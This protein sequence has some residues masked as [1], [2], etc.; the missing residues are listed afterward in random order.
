MSKTVSISIT[1]RGT[2][3]KTSHDDV[4]KW[5]LFPR[6]YIFVVHTRTIY[7]TCVHTSHLFL[8]RIHT[9]CAYHGHTYTM[10][11]TFT[12]KSYIFTK[13]TYYCLPLSSSCKT[14]RR[15]WTR[16]NACRIYCGGV[17]NML[18]VLSITLYCHYN[19]WG[20]MCSTSPFQFRRSKGN[21]YTSYHYH[22]QI[23]SIH[24]SHCYHIFPWFCA[25]DGCYIIFVH[26]LHI[27][28]GKTGISFS[29][30]LHILWRVQTVGY[31][32]ACRSYSFV[33]TV[34]HLSIIILPNYLKTLN[35]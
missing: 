1:R 22:H 27:H 5:K 18:L 33:C 31:V 4:S 20:C 21:I 12:Q 16:V 6:N 10:Y 9:P 32:L 28:S 17:S 24:L 25:W 26:L 3:R 29:L 13:G 35:L 23:G 15:H 7:S 19:I 30:S 2:D 14:A 11:S 8:M 34:H